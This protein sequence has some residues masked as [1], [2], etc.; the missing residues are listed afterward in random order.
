[1]KGGLIMETINNT[2]S[3]KITHTMKNILRS[4]FV[5]LLCLIVLDAAFA[6]E[7]QKGGTKSSTTIKETAAGCEPGST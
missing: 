1:M 3:F 4:L 2:R 6:R 7:V 5:T